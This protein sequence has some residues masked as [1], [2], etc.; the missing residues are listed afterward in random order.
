M[1]ETEWR[2]TKW[3]SPLKNL[4]QWLIF[5]AYHMGGFTGVGPRPPPFFSCIFET[6]LT[7][8]LTFGHK[9]SQNDVKQHHQFLRLPLSGFS[10]SGPYQTF[11]RYQNISFCYRYGR[12]IRL[13]GLQETLCFCLFFLYV[14]LILSSW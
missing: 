8:S 1:H 7:L 14:C 4:R 6:F 2:L 10:G 13:Q 5:T 12:K 11:Y 3:Y 9:C